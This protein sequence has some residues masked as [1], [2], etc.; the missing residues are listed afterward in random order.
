MTLVV[1]R[2]VALI[3]SIIVER[4]AA[5][6]S[7]LYN[8]IGRPTAIASNRKCSASDGER[9]G[10]SRRDA[11]LNSSTFLSEVISGTAVLVTL[12]SG[13]VINVKAAETI[14]I[15]PTLERAIRLIDTSCDR[16]Y[17]HAVVAS[18]YRFLYR[19]VP[20]AKN[21]VLAG[22]PT[23]RVEPCDLLDPTTYGSADAVR[24]FSALEE[25][26]VKGEEGPLPVRPSNGHLATTYAS[27]AA[28]WGEAASIW[29]LGNNVHFAWYEDRG[30]FWPKHAM[31]AA[32]AGGGEVGR[33]IVDGIDCG[34]VNLVDALEGEGCEVLFR[35]DK[36]L[37]VPI[38]MEKEL[39]DGLRQSFII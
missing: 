19:G 1:A 22:T 13:S 24:Y 30:N 20:P 21:A 17:L 28:Q 34:H 35:A 12:A 15:I 18:G 11:I 10:L 5:L 32:K 8:C 7:P 29:P 4:A 27:D 3:M 16:A 6:S 39:R 37:A 33:V 31:P 9:G 2:A 38:T 14:T 25:Q 23:V 36:F 26:M